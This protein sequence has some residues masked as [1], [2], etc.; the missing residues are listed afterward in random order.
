ML[1]TNFS[2]VFVFFS[3]IVVPLIFSFSY[4]HTHIYINCCVTSSICLWRYFL[5][6]IVDLFDFPNTLIFSLPDF[7]VI[8]TKVSQFMLDFVSLVFYFNFNL[9]LFLIL[10]YHPLLVHFFLLPPSKLYCLFFVIPLILKR[11]LLLF[12]MI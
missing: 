6:N 11:P 1:F 9:F 5:Y 10:S 4:T 7:P 8:F 12:K 2:Y 3:L